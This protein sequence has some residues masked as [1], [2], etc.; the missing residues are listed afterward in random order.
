M[1]KLLNFWKAQLLHLNPTVQYGILHDAS[2]MQGHTRY[3]L[4]LRRKIINC[5]YKLLVVICDLKIQKSQIAL[6][7]L[8]S[9]CHLRI[10]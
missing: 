3:I 2:N 10:A 8:I 1:G 9:G 6:Q 4:T 5:N 7:I